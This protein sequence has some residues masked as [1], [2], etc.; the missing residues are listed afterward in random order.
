[1]KGVV[2]FGEIIGRFNPEDYL[3]LVQT[4]KL[5]LSFAGGEANVAVSLEDY[6]VSVHL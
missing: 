1:M 2:Y 5:E 4:N 3:K 6:G